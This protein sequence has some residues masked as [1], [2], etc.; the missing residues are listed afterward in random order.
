MRGAGAQSHVIP[1][2][3]SGDKGQGIG[4][5]QLVGW[6]GRW[7]P[8]G[9]EEPK[10]ALGQGA[11]VHTHMSTPVCTCVHGQHAGP[12]TQGPSSASKVR[13]M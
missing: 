2:T 1:W 11:E 4:T 6:D 3:C 13:C 10:Q 8:R 9:L 7:Q 5:G 12:H